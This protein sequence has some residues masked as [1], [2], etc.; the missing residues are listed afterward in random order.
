MSTKT[1]AEA[2]AHVESS[3]E[4][5]PEVQPE[6]ATASEASE[7]SNIARWVTLGVI[8]LALAG[9][10]ALRGTWWPFVAKMI[11]EGSNAAGAT[12]GKDGEDH[13]HE[14]HDHEG[15]NHDH[16]GHDELNSIELSAQAK[17]TIGLTT[18][19]ITLGKFVRRITIPAMVVGRPGRS[20]LDVTAPLGGRV[21]RV[22]VV[23]GEAV[24]TGQPLFDLRLTHEELVR[25]QSEFLRTAEELDV[26]AREIQRLN[27]V[28]VP[29]AIAGKT[30]RMR[31]YEQ[32]KLVA[33]FNAQR[34]SLLLHG[35][36][37]EQV[38]AIIK[39]R[40]LIQGVTVKTP[41]HPRNGTASHDEDHPFTVRDLDVKPGQ[42]IDAGGTMTQLRDY[43]QLYIEGRAFEHDVDELLR[44]AKAG[45]E[46]TAIRETNESGTKPEEIKGLKIV[47]VDNEV[48]PESRAL[49]F[50]VRLPNEIVQQSQSSDGHHFSTWKFRPGQRMQVRVPVETWEDVIVLPVDAVAR[51]GL[52]YYVFRQNGDHFDR[53]PVALHYRDMVSAVIG[54]DGSLF[55][56][57]VVA[58]NN[59]HQLQ[60]AL[61]N[62]SGGGV[63]PHAGHNH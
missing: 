62:K 57:D 10:A 56:G 26:V 19:R 51:D 43:A 20:E 3:P 37:Q 25:A 14:G 44:A 12:A 39:D 27:S 15:H 59:A 31:E 30:V 4:V 35:L 54:N 53:V 41:P 46:I 45:W 42:Y 17:R 49:F 2:S 21:T 38:D 60:M 8:I 58:T 5:E 36:T 9:A 40:K 6:A 50:Y 16:E 33:M 55:A 13:D 22:Y 47:Y 7:G 11:G 34:Q 48:E 61:K 52:E 63:D 1:Q 32:Q 24:K 23:E 29:G 28:Q 18:G